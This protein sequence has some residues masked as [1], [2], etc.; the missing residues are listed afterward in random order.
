[1]GL[2]VNRAPACRFE[3]LRR[4]ERVTLGEARFATPNAAFR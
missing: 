4:I 3:E 2:V 1:M